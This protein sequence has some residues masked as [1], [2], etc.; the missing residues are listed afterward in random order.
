MNFNSFHKEGKSFTILASLA[1]LFVYPLLS[2]GVYFRDDLDRAAIGNY[3]WSNSGRPLA[4]LILAIASSSGDRL[5]DFFPYTLIFSSICLALS[6]L[7]VKKLLDSYELPNSLMASSLLIFNPFMLQNLAYRYDS[8]GMSLAFLLAILSYTYSHKNIKVSTAIKI[9]SG[10]CALSLYQPCVNI[11]L[12]IMAIEACILAIKKHITIIFFVRTIIIRSIV[13][14]AFYLVYM[15]TVAKIYANSNTRN[16]FISLN[17]NGAD[18][19]IKS[20]SRLNNLI[21]SY[22]YGTVIYYFT[23]TIFVLIAAIIFYVSVRKAPLINTALKL[24]ISFLIFYISLV[25][26]TI[27]LH[28]API[29][30]RTIVS[31]SCLFVMFSIIFIAISKGLRFIVLISVIPSLSFS[32]QLSNAL[33]EQKEHEDFV[34]NMI[35]YDILNIHGIK[36]ILTVGSINFS[37]RAEIISKE[38]PLVNASVSRATEFLATYQL[39]NKGLPGVREG[40]GIENKN[41][42]ILNKLKEENITPLI[43]N[44]EYKIYEKN[45]V[46]VVELGNGR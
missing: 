14:I 28:D 40:Y 1:I 33:H 45:G 3:G 6:C 16:A 5:L 15:L 8:L 22:M 21:A 29:Y 34:I 12:G 7:L 38:R 17:S 11:Y 46:A 19:L 32:A 30:A 26:P 42:Q 2:A 20:F 41:K 18:E 13:F 36:Q 10:V 39:Y 44:S 24:L 4:D 37:K 25:G 9:A 35:S 31:F 23:V 43:S 27:A